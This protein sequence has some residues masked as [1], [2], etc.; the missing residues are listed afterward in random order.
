MQ[1][2][3]V[4]FIISLA[5]IIALLICLIP[6]GAVFSTSAAYFTASA[7]SAYV[8]TTITCSCIGYTTG[9]SYN[10][11]FNN[12]IVAAGYIYTT[13][14][15]VT[16]AVPSLPGATYSLDIDSN[17]DNAPAVNFQILPNLSISATSAQVGSQIT[18]SGT[19]FGGYSTVYF[20][21]DGVTI[22]GTPTTGYGTFTNFALTMPESYSGT[23]HTFQAIDNSTPNSVT[24]SFTILPKLTLVSSAAGQATV[25]GTG[26]GPTLTITFTFDGA[27][28]GTVTST[29]AG[30]FA[31]K[32]LSLPAVSAG[33]HSLKATDT[34]GRYDTVTVTTVNSISISPQTG[35]VGSKVTVT[36]T[37]FGA[38]KPVTVTYNNSAVQAN[39]TPVGDNS[40]GF[41]T[42]FTVPNLP[43]AAYTITA[44]DGA[45]TASTKFTST[46]V[47]GSGTP[48]TGAVGADVPIFGYGF[49]AGATVN[50][51]FDGASISTVKA[52]NTGSLSTTLKLPAV[53]SGVHSIVASDGTNSITLNISITPVVTGTQ[54]SGVVGAPVTVTGQGFGAGAAI[55][56]KQDNTQLAAAT[57]DSSGSFSATFNIPAGK[58]GAHQITATDGVNSASFNVTVTPS[59]KISVASG[60]AGTSVTISGTAFTP[61]AQLNVKYDTD[62]LTSTAIGSDG[63][64]SVSFKVPVSK[65]GS[66][67]IAA[68]DGVNNP[69]FTFNLTA[70]ALAAPV[71]NYPARDAKADSPAKFQ[72]NLV[73][74]PNGAVT[75]RFQISKDP[76]FSAAVV[77]QTGLTDNSIQLSDQVKL[78]SAGKDNPYY[79]RVQAVDAA[80]DVSPWSTASTFTVGFIWP[81]WL[82]YLIYA[83]AGIVLFVLGFLAGRWRRRRAGY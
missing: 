5:V 27:T 43:S 78:E 80:G 75:Y 30:S 63:S 74:S 44:S 59:A 58:A 46:A 14:F 26:F 11:T 62:T 50:V 72:W 31:A 79:W 67:V 21:L 41:S 47:A 25:S 4:S 68:T 12:N 33:S 2:R 10:L 29:A 65:V 17:S 37:G 57:S 38:G 54:G 55:S 18:L 56:V 49:I 81:T 61:S 60:Y 48:A 9:T 13:N 8:G 42:T 20:K 36:G 69:T 83:I 34:G 82:V 3:K 64:F 32:A 52:D 28:V 7:Y 76:G 77:D 73:A 45:G 23:A 1:R 53:P 66:H 15:V 39:P 6:V 35:P 19:G 40:G 70:A 22:Q 16:F 51:N 71:L 24:V